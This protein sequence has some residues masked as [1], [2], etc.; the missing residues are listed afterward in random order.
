MASSATSRIYGTPHGNVLLFVVAIAG[1]FVALLIFGLVVY[2]VMFS[3]RRMQTEADR[4]TLV[5]AEVLNRGDRTGQMNNMVAR[6]RE[7]VYNSR[8]IH[9]RARAGYSH[10]EPLARQLLEEARTGARL[11]EVERQRLVGLNVRQVAGAVREAAQQG[12]SA[13]GISFFG[14]RTDPPQLIGIDVG[15]I[16]GVRSSVDASEGNPELKSQ[17]LISAYVDKQ[18]GLY[19]GNIN[20]KLHAPDNDLDFK[21]A[22]LQAP[23]KGQ[24]SQARLVSL[25][26][27][28]RT[29]RVIEESEQKSDPCDQLPS[30]LQLIL[31]MKVSGAKDG[32][33]DKP[34]RVTTAATTSGA[35]PP[36]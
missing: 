28:K 8:M 11:V 32:R 5:G 31:E 17:D 22:S 9:E 12:S 15:Y 25:D 27:F 29:A 35:L 26:M 23:Q 19:Q 36:P 21:I 10:L 14:V 4:L 1:V 20:A 6:S 30:A 3:Q 24:A 18:S 33:K 2:F 13:S 16:N 7:L 34:V